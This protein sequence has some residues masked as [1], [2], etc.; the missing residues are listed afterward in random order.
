[1]PQEQAGY[2]VRAV[3]SQP[4]RLTLAVEYSASTPLDI[5]G[6]VLLSTAALG[7]DDTLS[8]A[9]IAWQRHF[10]VHF[11]AMRWPHWD[12]LTAA[13]WHEAEGRRLFDRLS[14]ALPNTEV[15]LSLWPVEG[16]NRNGLA[17]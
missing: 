10:D 8:E 17:G 14:A 6:A 12:T 9:L 7:L 2:T 3:A 1:M 13:D 5:D 11:S 4:P 16:D 15:T